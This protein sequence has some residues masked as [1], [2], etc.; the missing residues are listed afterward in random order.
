MKSDL[1]RDDDALQ[2]LR[3]GLAVLK[4]KKQELEDSV[5]ELSKEISKCPVCERE[6]DEELRHRLLKDKIER[7]SEVSAGIEKA[8]KSIAELTGK[9]EGITKERNAVLL[10][11]KKLDDYKGIDGLVKKAQGTL[12]GREEGYRRHSRRI[13]K[14]RRRSSKRSGRG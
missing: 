11:G 12:R 4:G 14:K 2:E 8:S 7:S 5:D 10:A 6:L 3:K 1:K 13:L 9:I